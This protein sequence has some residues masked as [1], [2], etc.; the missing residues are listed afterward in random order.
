[1]RPHAQPSPAEAA[2]LA[3]GAAI[4]PITREVPADLVTPVSAFLGAAAGSRNAFLLESVEGGESLARYSFLG[5]N[6]RL[7]VRAR[8]TRVTEET[9][10]RRRTYEGN[11][12]DVLRQRLRSSPVAAVPGLPRFAS[13]AVGFIGYD[14][15]RLLE[16]IPD[17][18]S[19]PLGFDDVVFGFYDRLAA[20]DH[21]RQRLLLI[22][23]MRVQ[24]PADVRRLH[25]ATLRDLDGMER[26][27]TA[28][29]RI[30]PSAPAA[31][32]R[33]AFRS[34]VS[35]GT[36]EKRVRAAQSL[37]RA[38]EIFQV[39]LS[40]RFESKL[41]ATPFDVYR[42]LRRINPSPYMYCL[43]DGDDAIVG[44]SPEMLVRVEDD[45]LETRP[46]AGTRPR[47]AS[48]AED[49]AL[50]EE[51]KGDA[52]ERAEHLMLVDLARNDLGR[53]ARPGSIGVHGLMS[54]ERF[55]HVM[56]LVTRVTGVLRDDLD[57]FDALA[58]C[59]PAGTVSGA[60]KVRAM[61]VIEELEGTRRGPYAGAV[62]YADVAGNLD[63]C[64]TIR[65]MVSRGRRA[66]VQA[67]AGIVADS[68]PSREYEET[69]RKAEALI[70]A[71]A[72][73]R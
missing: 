18:G 73:A 48:E 62:A 31:R 36:F 22:A 32:R 14:A 15:V 28:P 63:S 20:F 49:R 67:G 38:G 10:G 71:V 4:I 45:R 29:R 58:A 30:R 27:L 57:A 40:Q 66:F 5:W 61:E 60:P 23:L 44:A 8:G 68:T 16:A 50:E 21:V 7:V 43:L 24:G 11:V 34:N 51:L 12:L 69:C 64:I 39:V 59:F 54:V 55:S 35:R 42:S 56:H 2:A 52:K 17:G 47:G 9:G 1:M 46:I 33:G 6:P 72:G 13:G 70:A 26:A 37:I 25:A 19:D 3:R 53:V 65:T 41:P